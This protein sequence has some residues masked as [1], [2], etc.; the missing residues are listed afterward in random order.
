[1][2]QM[3][4][5]AHA[6][7]MLQLLEHEGPHTAPVVVRVGGELLDEQRP[8]P[9][10][11]EVAHVDP[12]VVAA[13]VRRALG[14]ADDLIAHL[15]EELVDVL[16]AVSLDEPPLGER[17]LVLHGLA[18]DVAEAE[19]QEL[20]GPVQVAPVDTAHAHLERR[21][22]GIGRGG[23]QGRGWGAD[24]ARGPGRE[25]RGPVEQRHEPA[26]VQ[27]TQRSHDE[28]GRGEPVGRHRPHQRHARHASG[29]RRRDADRCVL[30]HDAA[31]WRKPEAFP[32]EL[33]HLRVGLAARDVATRHDGIESRRA[34]QAFERQL[35]VLGRPRRSHRETEAGSGQ[36][37]DE[38]DGAVHR[39]EVLADQVAVDGL[40]APVERRDVLRAQVRSPEARDDLA[41]GLSERRGEL[42]LHDR[43]PVLATHEEPAPHVR[44]V[45]I[46]QDAVDVEDHGARGNG[47]PRVLPE[48]APRCNERTCSGLPIPPKVPAMTM[49]GAAV[50][51]LEHLDEE[52]ETLLTSFDTSY[53][54]RY[55]SVKDGLRDLYEK[56]KR[57]QWNGTTQLAWDTDVDPEHAILPPA[58]N[59]LNGYAPYERLTEKEKNRLRHGQVALQLSQFLHGEQGAL[60]VASQLVGAVPWI[61]A[62]YYAGTQTMDEARHVEVFSRYLTEKLE[63]QWPVNE[64]LKELLDA[65]ITDGRWDFKYLGM[66]IIIEG[67]AMA[68]FGNLFQITRGPLLKELVRYVMKD[69]SR[70]VALGLL[71]LSDYY[72][73]MSESELRDR[74]D[75]II[76]ACELMRNRLVGDQIAEAMGWDRREVKE[77]VLTSPPALMFRQLLFARVV[78]NLKRLGLVSPRVRE[79]FE[80][81]G[82]IQFQDA[83]PEAQDRELGLA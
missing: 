47:H 75:F 46:D 33:E 40:L 53:A 9:A 24:I 71:S 83:D 41:A 61:D 82:I 39:R 37:I 80:R 58:I 52:L 50:N 45:G 36:R 19:L 16:L 62:K 64:N 60:I 43:E 31:R 44:V 14:V 57:D 10:L 49:S 6:S 1:E 17:T 2:H 26:R 68:A 20:P 72:A 56:A 48:P 42:L 74:E 27:L 55:G 70:H 15:E 51:Q 22:G 28:I 7:E 23:G 69:E 3:R 18:I 81:L 4:A 8:H 32:G 77:K 67:L 78:P 29:T 21:L 11:L 63:W 35:D 73:D 25:L 38:L 34:S 76:Y 66:Q 65:T 5:P 12:A 13:G 79:A 59:P 54:W 30:D